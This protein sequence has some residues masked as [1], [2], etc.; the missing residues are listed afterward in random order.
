M[1]WTLSTVAGVVSVIIVKVVVV[2]VR[3][4]MVVGM[5]MAV[6]SCGTAVHAVRTRGPALVA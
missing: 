4:R 2:I 3:Q 1:V 5:V 6:V